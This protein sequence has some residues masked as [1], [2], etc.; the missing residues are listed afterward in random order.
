[1]IRLCKAAHLSIAISVLHNSPGQLRDGEGQR[2]AELQVG[3][4]SL[5]VASAEV[6]A[7]GSFT[8]GAGIRPPRQ[9]L[10]VT[11]RPSWSASAAILGSTVKL[12]SDEA[13]RYVWAVRGAVGD[14]FM[15]A[16]LVRQFAGA[17]L[18]IK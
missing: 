7:T 15:W 16:H 4:S 13:H 11:F 1:M 2:V 14:E 8:P 18:V 3:A 10:Q 5:K 6:L 12:R 17:L 9:P